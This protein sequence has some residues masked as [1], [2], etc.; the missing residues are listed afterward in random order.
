[1]DIEDLGTDRGHRVL[2][3]RRKAAS[4]SPWPCHPRPPPGSTPAWPATRH[5]RAAGHPG[6]RGHGA[7]ADPSPPA[8]GPGCA[9]RRSGPCCPCDQPPVLRQ[10]SGYPTRHRRRSSVPTAESDGQ[11]RWQARSADAGE[12]H[13]PDSSQYRDNSHPQ[14]RMRAVQRAS[15]LAL[16]VVPVETSSR[17]GLAWAYEGWLGGRPQVKRVEPTPCGGCGSGSAGYRSW[18]LSAWTI[19]RVRSWSSV[20]RARSFFALSNSGWY[21][22]SSRGVSRL[23]VVVPPILRVH[24]A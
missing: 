1:M 20:S 15:D 7:A 4:F 21:S 22:A 16:H 12:G 8:P 5:H 9:G 13:L 6:Q 3:V 18:V 2:R 19:S 14:R 17:L 11:W 23:V 24:S 10:G